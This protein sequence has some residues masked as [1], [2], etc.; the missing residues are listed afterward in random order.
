MEGMEKPEAEPI[1]AG[2]VPR[3]IFFVSQGADDFPAPDAASSSALVWFW[4][5]HFCVWPT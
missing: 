5:N 3:Q 2:G 1:P 4:S